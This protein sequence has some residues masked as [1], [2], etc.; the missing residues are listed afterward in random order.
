MPATAAPG[1]AGLAT[2][3]VSPRTAPSGF[4]D[5]GNWYIDHLT[6]DTLSAFQ[7]IRPENLHFVLNARGISTIDYE[8]SLSANGLDGSDIVSEDF[9][10]PKRT[11]WYL[12]YG[13]KVIC[14][15]VH[16][17]VSG[18]LGQDYMKVAGVDW[19]G[20]LDGRFYP[21]DPRPDHVNDYCIG[22]PPQG[23]AY[24]AFDVDVSEIVNNLWTM[25]FSRPN[26]IPLNY[27]PD[28]VGVTIP[29]FRLDLGDTTSLLQLIQNL[30]DFFPGFDFAFD[31]VSFNLVISSPFV[32]GTIPAL[33]ADGPTG[34]NIIYN[35]D[36]TVPDS[37]EFTNT[38]PAQTHLF[39]TGTGLASELGTA[40]GTILGEGAFWRWDGQYDAGDV[41][42]QDVLDGMVAQQLSYGLN[43]VHEI[44]LT[45]DP[46]QLT[47]F[48]AKFTPGAAIWIDEDLLFHR[49]NSPQ[50][51]VSLDCT[52]GNEGNA[53]VQ[54]GVNQI[55]DTSDDAGFEEA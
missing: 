8:I 26:S 41:Y 49:I 17:S 44:P 15:G 39:G 38:G 13:S 54:V 33:I 27:V 1:R 48:W 22:T 12:R 31:P 46:N 9:I 34:P 30:A 42:S 53:Q 28:P 24:E 19:C 36:D 6:H 50:R 45:L 21:F 52:V 55:Y 23:L 51:I 2:P 3:S 32:F 11:G 43:P 14:S 47:D 40:L 5:P 18:V 37:I 20:Y 29:Y 35:T 10:H 25:I 4:A 16:T 7:T